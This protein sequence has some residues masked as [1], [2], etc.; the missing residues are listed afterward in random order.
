M[1]RRLHHRVE[2]R[3][4]ADPER[5]LDLFLPVPVRKAAP[6]SAYPHD[7]STARGVSRDIA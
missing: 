1:S 5:Q 2:H 4:G 3:V 7:L 6:A